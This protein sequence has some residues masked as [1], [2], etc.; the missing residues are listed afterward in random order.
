MLGIIGE[1]L[2]RNYHETRQLPNFVIETVVA[3][4]ESGSGAG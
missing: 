1:Y 2:W 4:P 3:G